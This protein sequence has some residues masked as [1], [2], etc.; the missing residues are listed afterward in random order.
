MTRYAVVRADP[1]TAPE[2]IGSAEGRWYDLDDMPIG[3]GLGDWEGSASEVI[4]RATGRYEYRCATVRLEHVEQACRIERAE[5][6]EIR[7][8]RLDQ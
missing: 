3:L 7:D 4:A 2:F 5:V 1:D 8:W 6:Y